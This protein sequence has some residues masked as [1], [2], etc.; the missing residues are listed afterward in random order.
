MSLLW[1]IKFH[2]MRIL[3]G[4]IEKLTQQ[5]QTATAH[6]NND[7]MH[8]HKTSLTFIYTASDYINEFL[9]EI[10]VFLQFCGR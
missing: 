5:R 7:Q 10:T 3:P 1:V 2:F 4:R 9:I 6:H 8:T